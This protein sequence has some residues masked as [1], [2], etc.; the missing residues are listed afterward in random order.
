[1]AT[2]VPASEAVPLT[3][4]VEAVVGL[5]CTTYSAPDWNARLPATVIVPGAPDGPGANAPPL[6][7]MVEPTVPLPPSVAPL[8]TV[9][10]LD[11]AIEPSTMRVPASTVVLPV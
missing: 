4:V 6:L 10:R 8:L 9:V 2:T 3:L 5:T 1:L 7:M 11:E